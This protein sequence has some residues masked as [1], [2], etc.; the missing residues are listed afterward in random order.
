PAGTRYHL[1]ESVAA[2]AAE[3]LAEAGEAAEVR[4]RHLDFHL[5]QA[6]RAAAGLH[7]ADQELW[8][9]RLDAEGANLRAALDTAVDAGRADAAQRLAAAL[10]WYWALRGRLAEAA[11]ALDR[12]LAL[13][14]EGGAVSP[15]AA[16]SRVW[17][18]VVAALR[19]D[20][21]AGTHRAAALAAVPALGDAAAAG[22]ALAVLAYTGLHDGEV[23]DAGSLLADARARCAAAGDGWGEAVALAGLAALAHARADVEAM[24]SAIRRADRLFAAAGDGWGRAVVATLRAAAAE[25]AGDLD[26]AA[27]VLD[28][29]RRAAERLGLWT[30]VATSLGWSAWIDVERGEL[31]R[32][33]EVARRALRLADEQGV[34]STRIQAAMALAFAARRAG[35]LDTAEAHLRRLLDWAGEDPSEADAAYLTTVLAELGRV[36][37]RR[38]APG[39]AV[40][41]LVRALDLA[42]ARDFPRDAAFALLGGALV[43]AQQARWEDVAR[44]LGAV[45][46]QLADAGV[47][48]SP[49]EQQDIDDLRARSRAAL[50]RGSF[51]ELF[52]EGRAAGPAT[53]RAL[54]LAAGGG[55]SGRGGPGPQTWTPGSPATT[56]HVPAVV[57]GESGT[58]VD[59]ATW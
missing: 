5:A 32:A 8:L 55:P 49:S 56:V 19:G 45:D 52:R 29:G 38:G 18:A 9:G 27:R 26:E 15:A 33:R 40:E 43:A 4:G 24:T 50:A 51:D 36:T 42:L 21:A 22:R 2:Y 10:G 28:E 11:R 57:T 47:A 35:D 54:L 41:L 46:R 30:E 12:S 17:R 16:W 7:G 58:S 14:D 20:P 31:D 37:A 59:S 53:A 34:R 25:L 6:E 1:L 39:P 44:L 13:G 23:E 48:A 3:R